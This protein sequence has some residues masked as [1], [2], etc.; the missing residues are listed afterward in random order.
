MRKLAVLMLMASIALLVP[1][2]SRTIAATTWTV[3]AGAAGPNESTQALRFLPQEITI[4]EG[5]TIQWVLG[6]NG[7]TVFFP[8]GQKAPELIIPGKMKGELLWNSD[9]MFP[10][11]KKIYA[12]SGP[13]SG[14]F[15]DADPN[16]PKSTAI[17]FSKAGAFK[18]VCM[19]HPGMEGK[20]IVQVAGSSYPKT[21]EE[22]S[23]IGAE[24]AQVALVKAQALRD[25]TKPII[26]TKA[27]KRTFTLNLVGDQKTMATF[28]RFPA[29]TLTISRGDSVTWA[30]KDPT[31]VHTVTFGADQ[32]AV[33]IAIVKPQPQG[34][35]LITVNPKAIKPSGGSVHGGPGFHNSGF[36]LTEGPG[37]RSYTLTFTRHGTF[38]YICAVHALLGMKATVVVK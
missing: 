38:D 32:K 28:L 11:P 25:E 17:T 19:F 15:M 29:Q 14:G 3:K 37:V 33:D 23:R 5:D 24:E 16:A 1:A 6:G 4:K 21:Q 34:P 8:A 2:P 36:L 13:F 12:G 31:E 18:Y 7:H 10:S 35:P 22:Y 9:V 27:G 26:T 20:V 30:M